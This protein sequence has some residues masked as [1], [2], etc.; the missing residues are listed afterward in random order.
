[1]TKESR[2]GL[3]ASRAKAAHSELTR[4]IGN[5]GERKKKSQ[6]LSTPDNLRPWKQGNSRKGNER[7]HDNLIGLTAKGS[8]SRGA[9]QM[10]PRGSAE[11]PAG[12]SQRVTEYRVFGPGLVTPLGKRQSLY[13]RRERGE[14]V[15]NRK[16]QAMSNHPPLDC[17]RFDAITAREGAAFRIGKSLTRN[18]RNGE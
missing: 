8:W 15:S 6:A 10:H 7:G 13:P 14:D 4:P 1:M 16:E 9:A 12:E 5:S 11:M 2:H 3:P 18:A 17:W